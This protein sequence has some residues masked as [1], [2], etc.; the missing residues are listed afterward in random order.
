MVKKALGSAL[1][2][3]AMMVFAY[4]KLKPSKCKKCKEEEKTV[5]ATLISKEVKTDTYNTGTS[6]GVGYSYTGKFKTDT[7]IELNL[8][9]CEAEFNGISENMRG[10]LTYKGNRLIN[11]KTIP[12]FMDKQDANGTEESFEVIENLNQKEETEFLE[13]SGD[14]EVGI[15]EDGLRIEKV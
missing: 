11:F 9:M 15:V 1:V 12:D 10:F 7:N 2:F 8:L 5:S 14:A 3:G 6:S 4:I 13:E